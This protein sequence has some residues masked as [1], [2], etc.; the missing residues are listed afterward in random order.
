MGLR[1]PEIYENSFG[2]K[3]LAAAILLD[4][5]RLASFTV[6]KV[7]TIRFDSSRILFSKIT[8]GVDKSRTNVAKALTIPNLIVLGDD[9]EARK[10]FWTDSMNAGLHA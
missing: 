10:L 9:D 7:G 6:K 4:K 5:L 8:M 3:T 1:S 2:I